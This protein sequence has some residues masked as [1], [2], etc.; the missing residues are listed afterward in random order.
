[1]GG[2]FIVLP[3]LFIFAALGKIWRWGG[4]EIPDNPVVF[5]VTYQ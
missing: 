3:V 1:M 4:E 5:L 2:N